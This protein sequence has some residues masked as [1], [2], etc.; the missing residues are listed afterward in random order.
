M[1]IPDRTAIIM[2][3]TLL[4][5]IVLSSLV[6]SCGGN[7]APAGNET[8]TSGS[9]P[10]AMP[11][12]DLIRLVSPSANQEIAAG[13]PVPIRFELKGKAIPDSVEVYFGG[14]IFATLD[15]GS[16]EVLIPE[17]NTA[18][19]GIRAIKL[20]AYSGK[21][22]PQSISIFI[23]I[24]SDIVPAGYGY[25]VEK[26]FP[27]DIRAYTQGLLYHNGFIYEGTGLEGKSALRK[28]DL[29]TGGVIRNHNLESRFFGEGI[30]IHG[31]QIYQLTWKTKVGFVYD[32]ET[33]R[34]LGRFYYNT[35]GW[36]LT[37]MGDRLVM[38]DGTNKLYFI[39]PVN[40]T[41]VGTIEVYD[42]KSLVMYLNELEYI[43]GEIWANVYMTDLIARIDPATGKVNGYVD[44]AGIMPESERQNDGD[45]VLNGIAWDNETGR[46]FVTGKNWPKLFQIR[47]T[48]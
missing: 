46:I 38:S 28:T 25:R 3:I 15:D 43:N 5:T 19:T 17:E 12:A 7:P 29:E 32:L 40:Y 23:T 37:T 10:A 31:N 14:K 20:M 26:V 1:R 48:E 9:V 16:T 45:D 41:I 6:V 2:S 22:R 44:L 39:E 11:A 34:E 30:T 35:E 4:C 42:N 27:H 13:T 8:K 36:G 47:I 18:S 33:F 21:A 24:L